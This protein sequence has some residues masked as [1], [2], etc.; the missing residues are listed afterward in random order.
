MRLLKAG[1]DEFRMTLAP[2]EVRIFIKS[3]EETI[4]QIPGGEYQTRMGAE[5]V[6]IR[7]A[8]ASLEAALQ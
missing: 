6:E 1:D 4:R 5:L 8:I 2:S 7:G 3:M